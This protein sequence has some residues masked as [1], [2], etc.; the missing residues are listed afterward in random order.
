LL[1]LTKK[2][3][4]IHYRDAY[5]YTFLLFLAAVIHFLCEA[6]ICLHFTERRKQE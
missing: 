6:G 3:A 2:S 1:E 4:M 5:A